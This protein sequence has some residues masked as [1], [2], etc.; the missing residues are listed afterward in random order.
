MTAR[1]AGR[2]LSGFHRYKGR[3]TR[4]SVRIRSIFGLFSTSFFFFFQ[5]PFVVVAVHRTRYVHK[6]SCRAC[7]CV[8]VFFIRRGLF[9]TVWSRDSTPFGQRGVRARLLFSGPAGHVYPADAPND[10]LYDSSTT[11]HFPRRKKTAPSIIYWR[12]FIYYGTSPT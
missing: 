1:T 10:S 8:C 7:V 12:T 9:I 2:E 3:E 11:L 4:G 6:S 5:V